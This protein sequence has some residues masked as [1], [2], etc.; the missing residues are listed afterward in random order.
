MVS[1]LG[2]QRMGLAIGLVACAV[3]V[4]ASSLD[5]Q[6]IVAR[7]SIALLPE[8]LARIFD[9]HLDELQERVVEP[10]AVWR[11][12]PNLHKRL[13]WHRVAMDVATDQQTPDDRLA[14]ARAFPRERAAA[15]RLYRRLNRRG[16]RGLL[17]WAIEDFYNQL[18]TAFREGDQDQ[19]VRTAAYLMHFAT[20][21]A[22]PFNATANYDGKATG[23]LHLGRIPMG[24]PHYAHRSVA[25]R[26]SGELVR[27][28]RSRFGDALRL[29]PGDY[30]PVDDPLS[31]TR[32]VL[33]A[34]LEVLDQITETDLDILETMQVTDGKALMARTDEYYQL[35]DQR[36]GPVC[37]D[38]LRQATVFAANL[39]GGAWSAAGKPTA[40]R[41]AL[42]SHATEPAAMDE[43]GTESENGGVR[44]EEPQRP[45]GTGK[46]VGSSHTKVYH[47]PT[48]TWAKKIA[49]ENRVFFKSTKEAQKQGRRACKYCGSVR[50]TNSQ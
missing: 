23:N 45:A 7:E 19:A 2:L 1:R 26:F 30:E 41:I 22:F 6:R 33:L 25:D 14:A 4:R 38:R 37:V 36:V 15:K 46:L 17:P 29:A 35:L 21:A 42:R 13:D 43:S 47:R 9:G 5:A 31:R 44:D 10:D 32:A 50:P 40:E 27:R 28:N 12:D 16:G 49:P 34:A 3:E 48:C 8:T 11:R 20:D 18:V 39:V 24:H